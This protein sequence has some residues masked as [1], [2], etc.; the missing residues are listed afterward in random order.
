[1]VKAGSV[2]VP[3]AEVSGEGKLG[4]G[5]VAMQP[6]AVEQVV[7]AWKPSLCLMGKEKSTGM[8][9]ATLK[10]SIKLETV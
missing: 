7:T 8:L 3:K 5:S 9:M 2:E 4:R 6:R 10:K 1:M